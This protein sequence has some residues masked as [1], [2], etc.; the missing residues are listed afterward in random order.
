MKISFFLTPKSD[1]AWVST[2]ATV[3]QALERMEHYRY[4]S[5]PV[6]TPDGSFDGTLTEG[7]LLWYL[8]N[9]PQV[10]FKDTEHLPLS[11]VPRRTIVQPISIDSD[12]EALFTLALDQNFVSVVDDRGAFIGIVRRKSILSFFAEKVS[13]A[14]NGAK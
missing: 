8:K 7:D 12:I 1:V 3:R 13:W 14:V 11:N 9:N 10:T 6:L 5:V 4:S 2:T